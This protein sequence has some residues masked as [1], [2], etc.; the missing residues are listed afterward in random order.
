[1]VGIIGDVIQDSEGGLELDGGDSRPAYVVRC[2]LHIREKV[3]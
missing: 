3:G 2:R 1:V